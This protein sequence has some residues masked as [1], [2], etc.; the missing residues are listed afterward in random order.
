M[1]GQHGVE[2]DCNQF[3]CSVCLELLNEPVTI[4][5]GHSYCKSCIEHCWDREDEKGEY[6]CP[7]CME[8]S[9]PRPVLRRNNMLA[10]VR[11][12]KR[13]FAHCL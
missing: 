11:E 4:Y 3:S 5:C 10:E 6:S 1:A 9:S 8:T 7:Q 12:Q 2:L 13:T